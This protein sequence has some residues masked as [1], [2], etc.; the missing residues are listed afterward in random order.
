VSEHAPGV[1]I[2]SAM[3]LAARL[4]VALGFV[5][6]AIAFWLAQPTR[7]TLVLGGALAMVGE[8][9]RF[10]AAGHLQ[11]S[12]EVTTSGPYRWCAH[13]LYV[14]SSVMGVGLAIAAAKVAVAVL[15]VSYLV[16]TI[17]AAVLSE[18]AFL[19]QRFGE[20]Y[21]RYRR[22]APADRSQ[23]KRRFSLAQAIANHE[24]RALSGLLAAIALLALKA[25]YRL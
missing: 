12:R 20:G 23:D 14:G 6:G 25:R 5:L 10:W 18:E 8:S 16:V 4:R 24:P 21:D 22:G 9:I 19:R 13:P 15:V 1:S 2:R 17:T 7:D 3:A 11:K